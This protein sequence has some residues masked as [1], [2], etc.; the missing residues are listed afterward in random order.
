MQKCSEVPA[1][2]KEQVFLHFLDKSVPRPSPDIFQIFRLLLPAV[3][4][5][6]VLLISAATQYCCALLLACAAGS[7][8]TVS[9]YFG[10]EAKSAGLYITNCAHCRTKPIHSKRSFLAVAL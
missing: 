9:V 2:Q 4:V 1:R 3:S 6:L 5:A 10:S 7:A 8:A